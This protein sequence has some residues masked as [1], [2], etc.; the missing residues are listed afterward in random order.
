M[1]ALLV[2]IPAAGA[3]LLGGCCSMNPPSENRTA[4]AWEELRTAPW[5]PPFT[6]F[7]AQ[8]KERYDAVYTP[9]TIAEYGEALCMEKPMEE[10][11]TCVNRLRRFYA[12]NAVEASFPSTHGPFAFE[13]GGEVFI[14]RYQSTPFTASFQAA[15]AD[16]A[17]RG[18]YN[19]FAGSTEA[20]FD[21]RCDDGRTGE[22]NIVLDSRGRNG[23]GRIELSDGTSG[24]VLFGYGVAEAA[25]QI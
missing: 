10:Y 20:V 3:L 22:A 8:G 17:C 5:I 14:G 19:A 2:L 23:I 15:N 12:E 7:C 4:E 11:A 24:R 21:V 18:S 1:K 6:G 25:R 9:V 13:A 16:I